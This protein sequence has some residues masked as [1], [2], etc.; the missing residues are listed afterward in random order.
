LK[1]E[2]KKDT[3]IKRGKRSRNNIN[4]DKSQGLQKLASASGSPTCWSEHTRTHTHTH[5]HTCA[6]LWCLRCN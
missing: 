3:R 4:A 6:S 1:H 5:I 2:V